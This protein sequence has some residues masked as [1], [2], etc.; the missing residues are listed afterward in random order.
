MSE[1]SGQ[2]SDGKKKEEHQNTRAGL[3]RDFLNVLSNLEGK[4]VASVC[5]FNEAATKSSNSLENGEKV[6]FLASDREQLHF[7][8]SNFKT[9][10]GEVLDSVVIRATDVD[11]MSFSAKEFD[12]KSPK[13]SD[14]Q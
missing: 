3:R 1:S 9:P 8:L 12:A 10:T 6:K 13:E 4:P 2:D 7:I 5:M 14:N 11:H